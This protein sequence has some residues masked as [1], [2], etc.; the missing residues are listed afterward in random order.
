VD[1]YPLFQGG[2]KAFLEREKNFSAVG[3]SATLTNDAYNTC[4]EDAFDKDPLIQLKAQVKSLKILG[5]FS[6]RDAFHVAKALEVGC[7]GYFL[8]SLG[9]E[10]LR[11]SII[12]LYSSGVCLFDPSLLESLNEFAQVYRT[13]DCAV[14][15]T[16]QSFFVREKK[17]VS[18]IIAGKSNKSIG[19]KLGLSE[20]YIKNLIYSIMLKH[21]IHKRSQLGALLLEE[22]QKTVS[23]NTPEP[24]TKNAPK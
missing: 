3:S 10:E 12:N 17:I 19:N 4:V 11:E 8:K 16:S 6:A 14:K 23:G 1:Q 13:A 20:S 21:G 18:M 15:K 22:S 24:Q 9:T 7:D 5:F 2:L